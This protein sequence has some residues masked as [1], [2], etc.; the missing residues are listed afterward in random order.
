MD[1]E[2]R[3]IGTP[4]EELPHHALHSCSTVLRFL[5]SF[6]NGNFQGFQFKKLHCSINRE[7]KQTSC[8]EEN[9]CISREDP[10][11]FS[12]IKEPWRIFPCIQDS[13]AIEKLKRLKVRYEKSI[14][15]EPDDPAMIQE[16]QAIFSLAVSNFKDVILGDTVLSPEERRTKLEILLDYL[17]PEA[18]RW[19][20]KINLLF[21]FKQG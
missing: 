14:R 11:M 16:L 13:K 12:R 9:G 7:T 10:C 2:K 17:G 19:K 15:K 21:M 3:Y 5:Y 20:N 18:T 1:Q 4:L 8:L 6:N